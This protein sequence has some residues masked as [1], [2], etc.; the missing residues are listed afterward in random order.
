[1]KTPTPMQQ[2]AEQAALAF[3]LVLTAVLGL[4]PSVAVRVGAQYLG[5]PSFAGFHLGVAVVSAAVALWLAAPFAQ[6]LF[7]SASPYPRSRL[8][9]AGL[10]GAA[11]WVGA[12]SLLPARM[13]DEVPYPFT[14]INVIE[15]ASLHLATWS[16]AVLSALLVLV[17]GSSIPAAAAEQCD[18]ADK[19][20]AG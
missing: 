7:P 13:L 5:L 6:H 19:V 16:V 10:A 8:V 15:E 12:D 2:Q 11:A 20:H 3:S 4:L 1:M 18:E 9:L 14:G 17:A